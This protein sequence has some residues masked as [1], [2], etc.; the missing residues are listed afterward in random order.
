[1][2]ML[3]NSWIIVNRETG[4]SVFETYNVK[5]AAAVNTAKYDVMSAHAYLVDLN[6]RIK[7]G[8]MKGQ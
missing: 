6:R 4:E 2:N 8:E 7:A 5:I 1:M 3:C